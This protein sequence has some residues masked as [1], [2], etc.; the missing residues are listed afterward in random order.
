[1]MVNLGIQQ[2]VS[3]PEVDSGI[4]IVDPEGD[5]LLLDV[6]DLGR[7]VLPLKEAFPMIEDVTLDY[8]KPHS[9]TTRSA[10]D[11]SLPKIE[12]VEPELSYLRS[13]SQ[14][15]LRPLSTTSV[16]LV[17]LV[18]MTVVTGMVLVARTLVIRRSLDV[19]TNVYNA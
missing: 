18:V 12:K 15:P 17:S 11:Q 7:V 6:T 14:Q 13:T 16:L 4:I 9:R 19:T 8:Q 1:M 5:N 2:L 10:E 3:G